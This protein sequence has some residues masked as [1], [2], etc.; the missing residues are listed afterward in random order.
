MSIINLG[1][2]NCTFDYRGKIK[3]ADFNRLLRAIIKPGIYEGLTLSIGGANLITFAAGK[4]FFDAI[5]N[6]DN[7]YTT[8]VEFQSSFNQTINQTTG[9]EN[10]VVWFTYDYSELEENWVDIHHD[11]VTNFIAAAPVNAVVVGDI[12]YTAGVATSIDYTRRTYGLIDL[13]NAS[14]LKDSQRFSNITTGTKRFHFDASNVTAGQDRLVKVPDEDIAIGASPDWVANKFYYKDST[15]VYLGVPYRALMDHT[16]TASFIA[17]LGAL[18]WEMLGGGG[19]GTGD[20]SKL[21]LGFDSSF[22]KH[23]T[24]TIITTDGGAL[25]NDASSTATNATDYY[26]FGSI[27]ANLR[28]ENLISTQF[29]FAPKLIDRVSLVSQWNDIYESV[30]PLTKISRDGGISWVEAPTLNSDVV[31]A[32]EQSYH[33]EYGSANQNSERNLDDGT[34][35]LYIGQRFTT[36]AKFYCQ[37][38]ELYLKQD[39]TPEGRVK[40]QIRTNG[41]SNLPS[42][43]ILAESD[44]YKVSEIPSTFSFIRFDLKQPLVFDSATDYHIVITLEDV[45]NYDFVTTTSELV[46]GVDTTPAYLSGSSKSIDGT[47]FSSD[48]DDYIFRVG[49]KKVLGDPST[50]ITIG[51]GVF[52][53]DHDA[54]RGLELISYDETHASAE[55]K[56]GETGVNERY[57]QK[58]KFGKDFYVNKITPYLKLTGTPGGLIELDI[59]SDVGGVPGLLLYTPVN[60]IKANSISATSEYRTFTFDSPVKLNA[61][62]NYWFVLRGVNGD[63]GNYTY[64]AINY[65]GIQTDATSVY[66]QGGVSAYN[67]TTWGAE[68]TASAVV[69]KVYGACT[70]EK[71]LTLYDS[72]NDVSEAVDFTG[73]GAGAFRRLAQSIRVGQNSVMDGAELFLDRLGT[74]GGSVYLEVHA[75]SAG[76]PS[77]TALITSDSIL[78]ADIPTGGAVLVRFNFQERLKLLKNTTY[79]IVARTTST[80]TYTTGV[81]ELR[82]H[83]D[84][85]E[86][87]YITSEGSAV[88]DAVPVWT[89]DATK[90]FVFT[91]F[92]HQ[93]ELLIDVI[94]RRATAQL[95]GFS[96]WYGFEAS[97]YT[98]DQKVAVVQITDTMRSTG[99]IPYGGLLTRPGDVEAIVGNH[100]LI[101]EAGDF[102]ANENSAQF[103]P[104]D[105]PVGIDSVIFR[106]TSNHISFL[107]PYLKIQDRLEGLPEPRLVIDD[108]ETIRFD[109]TGG[110]SSWKVRL[111]DGTIVTAPHGAKWSFNTAK[112]YLGGV[113][114]DSGSEA[115]S[116]EYYIYIVKAGVRTANIVVSTT[117]PINGGPSG[118]RYWKCV[119]AFYNN[120]TSNIT[121]IMTGGNGN[122]VTSDWVEFP[123]TIGAVTT[124]PTKATTP[125]IDKAYWRRVGDSMEI[126]YTYYAASATGAFAGTGVY[127][128]NILS[129]YT[130]NTSKIS[131]STNTNV[132]TGVCGSSG[133]YSDAGNAV[134]HTK[135]HNDLSIVIRA[136]STGGLQIIG[137]VS[138]PITGAG[139]NYSFST[140]IPITGWSSTEF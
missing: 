53:S 97:D 31:L 28:S 134:G 70:D 109:S 5:F 103:N 90:D 68:S 89:A 30:T 10:E 131:E 43:V 66:S 129:G 135:V 110:A 2:Q 15:R 82:W 16:A 50:D 95:S 21:M 9:G 39:S 27:L 127:T 57:A 81:D 42:T 29:E 54:T 36:T 52:S 72:S 113:G 87:R 74:P 124:A 107:D 114:L 69:F 47:T 130:I 17:D 128:F 138:F 56:L 4:V 22:Y 85:T 77:G 26:N 58:F 48:G 32:E 38:V 104:S 40:V 11:S 92:G 18:K 19:G 80:Y 108:T 6:T 75:N 35:R 133:V 41:G 116:T 34:A 93:A 79:W 88:Y 119:G 62:T 126:A 71:I 99:L 86:P 24:Q 122:I 140:V 136:Y 84:T 73:D 14:S 132:A 61:N 23:A 67:G 112:N 59:Y 63:I 25:I 44:W 91:L 117:K 55:I 111:P 106:K 8:N 139:I 105:L 7:K 94:S 65:V 12:V 96:A 78:V 1:S 123:M 115:A 100:I 121:S 118:Y 98:H 51:E 3:G 49:G 64:T 137:S 13:N 120:A 101:P 102:I 33:V 125:D 60:K 45:R 20:V 76:V 46:W 37:F 83:R